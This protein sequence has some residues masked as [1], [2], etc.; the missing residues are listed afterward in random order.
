MRQMFQKMLSLVLIAALCLSLAAPVL[1]ADETITIAGASMTL[2]NDLKMNFL[3]KKSD[4]K[5]GLV[6][7]ITQAGKAPVEVGF[8]VYSN[9]YYTAAYSVAAKE[10]TDVLSCEI[11]N[12]DGQLISKPF[13]RTVRQYAM[14]LMNNANS[15]DDLRSVIVDMLNYG[16]EA[17][18][19][20]GYHEEDYANAE[21]TAEQQAYA[22]KEV[23][24]SDCRVSG[25]NF[26]GS[27]LALESSILLNAFFRSSS[28][29][30]MT[31]TVSYT[32]YKRR[33][34]TVEE[35][36]IKA[37]NTMVRVE[38]DRIVLADARCPVTVTVYKNGEI[39]GSCVDSVEG[40]A[41]RNLTA[42]TADL[43]AAI[44]KFSSSAFCYLGG[45]EEEQHNWNTGELV[46]P[47]TEATD[48]QALYTCLD[49]GCGETKLETIP[50]GTTVYTRAD[51]EEALTE[52]AWDYAFKKEKVQY[53]SEELDAMGKVYS[54][55]F[56]LT[57][58]APPE[59]GTSHTNINSVCSDYV[60]KIYEEALHHNL[61]GVRSSLEVSTAYMWRNAEN[62]AFFSDEEDVDSVLVRWTTMANSEGDKKYG[63]DESPHYVDTKEEVF[64]YFL[65]WETMLR[66]G[67]VVVDNGHTIIFAGNGKMLHCNGYKY[68]PV[69]GINNTEA[70]GAVYGMSPWECSNTSW[71]ESRASS[72]RLM[73]FRPTEFLATKDTD[74]DPGNDMMLD[75]DYTIPADTLSR[76]EYPGMEIDRT[77]D[78]TPFGTASVGQELTYSVK[79]S[80][81]TNDSKYVAFMRV[82]Q[83][84][85]TGVGY[86]DLIVTETVPEGTE[87]VSAT[88]G[89]IYDKATNT[90]TWT[91]DLA[92]GQVVTPAY[93]VK[94]TGE[95]GDTIV[96]GGGFVADIPSNVISNRIGCKKLSESSVEVLTGLA[97]GNTTN[98]DYGTDLAFAEGIYAETGIELSL[99][100]VAEIVEDLFVWTQTEG[101]IRAYSYSSK[102]D[103]DIFMLRENADMSMI[104]DTYYGG[105]RF[106]TGSDAVG[107]TLSEF[108]LEYLEPGDIIV[109]CNTENGEVT[110]AQVMVYAGNETLLICNANGSYQILKGSTAELQL[111]KS[112]LNTNELF[113]ALRPS[114][115][116]DLKT[117]HSWD[118]GKITQAPTCGEDGVK[119]YKLVLINGENAECILLFNENGEEVKEEAAK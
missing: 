7:K 32:D 83:P 112:F 46:L 77:V 26:V 9:V 2:G 104:I 85:Y 37:S 70:G 119:T 14:T 28:A 106:F 86:E 57:E 48:G 71:M 44:M 88:E 51:L 21:L 79:I 52:V 43:C 69:T 8:E 23:S 67:D 92:A 87:F 54:G 12:A 95:V 80:N 17:Q 40:Y 3:I 63:V 110:D 72:G 74:G 31:A 4:M 27:N 18:K 29:D 78:I 5:E 62:Q 41:A 68:S 35:E 84:D 53:D 81:L 94:V 24:V 66:P 6:A 109:N 90:I 65:N 1:A 38:V 64:E 105:Y 99:P 76:L 49:D 50:A 118:E 108:R 59:Y 91:L 75:P 82:A 116:T 19:Y 97:A 115:T 56:L 60:W 15:P 100:T 45:V 13:T 30:G 93:T 113:F 47:V 22:S 11:Y 89:G 55:K 61:L 39:F 33:P 25:D 102:G 73:I 16:T 20:F 107:S 36:V 101:E 103:R 58:N 111:W 10:M 117:T 98:W 42:D 96:S 114:Q 34:V